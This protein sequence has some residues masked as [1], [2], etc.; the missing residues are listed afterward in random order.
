MARTVVVTGG[1]A[2]IG[3]A[4]AEKFATEGWNVGV[5]AR[6]AGRLCETE[7]RLRGMGVA[8]LGI[9][10]DVADHEAVDRAAERFEGELGPIEAW[11]NNAMATVVAP[12]MRIEPD[13]YRRVTDVTYHGQVFGTLAALKRMRPRGRGAIVQINSALGIRP[14]PLQAAYCGAKGAALNFTNALR[15]EL[16]HEKVD[17][18]LTTVF[19]PAVNTPQ[20]AGWARNRTGRRQIAPNP[21]YDPRLCANAVHFAVEHPRRDIWVGR[22]AVLASLVQ[23]FWPN[24]GDVQAKGGWDAQLSDERFAENEGNLFKPGDGPARLHGPFG[25]RTSS[26]R[27]AFWTSRQRDAVVL[28]GVAFLAAQLGWFASRRLRDR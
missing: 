16:L 27:Q 13:E 8:A 4:C 24:A 21:V 19:L 15:S 18:T 22:T 23:R 28:G 25:D 5:I 10:A 2:G 17:V 14:F 3:L 7:E 1:T 11:V 6:D 20:F 12:A 9:E 26:A